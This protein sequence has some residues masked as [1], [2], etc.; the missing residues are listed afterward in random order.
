MKKRSFIVLWL[1]AA[2][3]AV[4]LAGCASPQT[5]QKNEHEHD[6]V[7]TAARAASCEE[8]GNIQYWYCDGCGKYFSDAEAKNEIAQADTV[9]PAKHTLREIAA[10]SADGMFSCNSVGHWRCVLCG[11]LFADGDAAQPLSENDVYEQKAFALTDA[12]VTAENAVSYLFA[13]T[14]DTNADLAVTQAEFVL[15]V[16]LGWGGGNIAGSGG[17]YRLNL[18]LNPRESYGQKW[19]SLR[20]GCNANGLY[21][22]FSDQAERFFSAVTGGDALIEEFGKQNGLYFVIVRRGAQFSAYAE[23]AAGELTLVTQSSYLGDDALKSISLG[24]N[25]SYTVSSDTPA[26]AKDGRLVI[27]TTEP[28]DAKA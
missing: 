21:A 9:L 18:N 26:L 1:A 17:N 20:F 16:F 6:L 8:D 2:L 7:R 14:D 25:T 15:R 3:V 10:V 11:A 4:C 19:F 22:H 23:N 12:A 5:E 13:K 27:G 24:V 28:A